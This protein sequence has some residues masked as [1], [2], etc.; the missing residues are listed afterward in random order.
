MEKGYPSV[1]SARHILPVDYFN[2]GDEIIKKHEEIPSEPRDF[3]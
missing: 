3:L 1:W 2:H